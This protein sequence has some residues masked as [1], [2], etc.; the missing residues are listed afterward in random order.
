M[1]ENTETQ[2]QNTS[3]ANDSVD[4]GAISSALVSSAAI[5]SAKTNATTTVWGSALRGIGKITKIAFVA[6]VGIAA[7][8]AG[9]AIAS[10][11]F[12]AAA[13]MLTSAGYAGAAGW[14]TWLSGGALGVA[15]AIVAGTAIAAGYG[16][17]ALFWLSNTAWPAISSGFSGLLASGSTDSGAAFVGATVASTAATIGMMQAKKAGLLATQNLAD[18]SNLP[19]L[20][21]TQLFAAK[22]I[23]AAQN[24]LQLPQSDSANLSQG[25]S[26]NNPNNFFSYTPEGHEIQQAQKALMG[27]NNHNNI[28]A[29]KAAIKNA[30]HHAADQTLEAIEHKA[31][32]QRFVEKYASQSRNFADKWT[33]K[34]EVPRATDRGID[35]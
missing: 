16:A 22:K 31:K 35:I 15:N 24:A 4:A 19:D 23:M 29:Q 34:V 7:L 27:H 17:G 6:V 9:S 2:S 11:V 28:L 10:G 8:W 33:D 25:L 26:V 32:P 14:A 5:S 21:H 20:N 12:A 3:G 1:M 30:A 18:T 13:P